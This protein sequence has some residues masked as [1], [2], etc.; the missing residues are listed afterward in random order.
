MNAITNLELL[1]NTKFE[2]FEKPIYKYTDNIDDIDVGLCGNSFK[3]KNGDKIV[4]E[5]HVKK[6]SSELEKQIYMEFDKECN[7][8]K[9]SMQQQIDAENLLE[10][11]KLNNYVLGILLI[12]KNKKRID[13]TWSFYNQSISIQELKNIGNQLIK[14]YKLK[15]L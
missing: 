6:I 12:F 15:Y 9:Y 10:N 5:F 8:G 2:F 4:I 11:N 7:S 14:K 3:N 13:Y 1:Y